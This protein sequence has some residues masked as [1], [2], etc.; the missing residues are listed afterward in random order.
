MEYALIVF[1]FTTQLSLLQLAGGLALGAGMMNVAHF[2]LIRTPKIKVP[3]GVGA[4]FI[5]VCDSQLLALI[6]SQ[7]FGTQGRPSAI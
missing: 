7:R 5:A 2:N 3:T 4:I 1:N 6:T